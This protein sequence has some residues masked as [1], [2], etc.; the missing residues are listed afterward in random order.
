MRRIEHIDKMEAKGCLDKF[1]NIRLKETEMLEAV[2]YTH[3]DV[4][5]RQVSSRF[6]YVVFFQYIH[7]SAF[8]TIMYGLKVHTKR[9]EYRRSTF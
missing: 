1:Y 6:V 3:L 8:F 5:K 7:I 9:L 4:Y 2:S